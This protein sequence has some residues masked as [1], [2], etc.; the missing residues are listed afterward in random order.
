MVF[1]SQAVRSSVSFMGVCNSPHVDSVHILLDFFL[2][3]ISVSIVYVFNVYLFWER[4][5][6]G[7][8]ER[9]SYNPKQAPHCYHRAQCEIMT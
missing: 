1:L 2:N 7:Q 3:P 8:R 4:E 9:K 6:E 5:R